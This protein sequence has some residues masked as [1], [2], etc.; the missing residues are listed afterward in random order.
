MNMKSVEIVPHE[1]GWA[2]LLSGVTEHVA[3]TQVIAT[4]LA[5][6]L[7]EKHERQAIWLLESDGIMRPH[8]AKSDATSTP[9]G[10]E[11]DATTAPAEVVIAEPVAVPANINGQDLREMQGASK[12]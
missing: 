9:A 4:S 11:R 1:H 7:T 5:Q 2:I 12:A 3:P 6:R 10:A 8:Q